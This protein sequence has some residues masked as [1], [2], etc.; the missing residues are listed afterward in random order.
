MSNRKNYWLICISQIFFSKAEYGV[1]K[2]RK[3]NTLCLFGKKEIVREKEKRVVRQTPLSFR[4]FFVPYFFFYLLPVVLGAGA[5]KV[6]SR[7]E[8][9]REHVFHYLVFWSK[10]PDSREWEENWQ[11]ENYML[12]ATFSFTR[13]VQL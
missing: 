3:F 4:V 10:Y 2:Y 7:M 13:I 1:T 8:I 6:N 9:K 12:D 5:S 11:T